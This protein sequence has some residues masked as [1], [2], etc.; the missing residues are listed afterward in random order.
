MLKEYEVLLILG[1]N[2]YVWISGL[3]PTVPAANDQIRIADLDSQAE[4]IDIQSSEI[5]LEVRQRICR[6]SNVVRALGAVGVMIHPESIVDAY[7][8]SL[9]SGI[10]IRDIIAAEFCVKLIEKEAERRAKKRVDF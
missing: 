1:C 8:T 10:E 5:S 9:S 4:K 3:P 6:L 2:G 7:E